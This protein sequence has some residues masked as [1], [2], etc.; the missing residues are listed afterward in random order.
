MTRWR[1]GS[2]DEDGGEWQGRWRPR[3]GALRQAQR[4]WDETDRLM[5]WIESDD[6]QVQIVG[7]WPQ[8]YG[9]PEGV[10]VSDA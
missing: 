4:W 7:E 2:A 9:L 3:D 8:G 1:A 10:L 6:G 5:A